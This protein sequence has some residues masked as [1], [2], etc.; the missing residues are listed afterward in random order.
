V[1]VGEHELLAGRAA[2]ACRLEF[3]RLDGA[4]LSA[5]GDEVVQDERLVE[6]VREQR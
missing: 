2:D 1:V 5:D 6:D 4:G 3:D